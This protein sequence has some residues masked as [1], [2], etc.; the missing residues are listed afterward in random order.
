VLVVASLLGWFGWFDYCHARAHHRVRQGH[1]VV[2]FVVGF[3]L[4]FG[5]GTSLGVPGL[6]L[7]S[8]QALFRNAARGACSAGSAGC[9]AT[10]A[11]GWPGHG[12]PQC[13]AMAQALQA[14]DAAVAEARDFG[15]CRSGLIPSF[16]LSRE[17]R[18]RTARAVRILPSAHRHRDHSFDG[19]LRTSP[20]VCSRVEGSGRG[21]H[22]E[23]DGRD[24]VDGLADWREGI[25]RTRLKRWT[26]SRPNTDRHRR[27]EMLVASLGT[28]WRG[29]VSQ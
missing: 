7:P 4:I 21:T 25:N 8:R 12:R 9:R 16:R 5:I 11:I 10:P 27:R 13:R 17:L 14:R 3:V 18:R 24:S 22:L 1:S 29:G 20:T 2:G 26:D 28:R 15:G 6:P 19:D 23:F